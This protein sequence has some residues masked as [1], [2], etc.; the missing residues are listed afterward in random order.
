MILE[1]WGQAG[2]M[3]QDWQVWQAEND[4]GEGLGDSHD[5]VVEQDALSGRILRLP[6]AIFTFRFVNLFLSAEMWRQ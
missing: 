2:P 6:A 1:H 3:G 5:A 4:R